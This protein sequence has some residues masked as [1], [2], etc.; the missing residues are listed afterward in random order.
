[1]PCPNAFDITR[2]MDDLSRHH[3]P[4]TD[5]F[6][7]AASPGPLQ[8]AKT[9][10]QSLTGVDLLSNASLSPA[11]LLS[12]RGGGGASETSGSSPERSPDRSPP[13][14][15]SRRASLTDLSG[16]LSGSPGPTRSP[17]TP[18]S[19]TAPRSP[20]AVPALPV[21]PQR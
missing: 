2:V 7:D 17:A 9:R 18:A 21:G 8:G 11:E 19:P 4:L 12:G 5:V 10:R 1:M 20:V 16:M 14:L 3:R 15:R 13:T 6:T